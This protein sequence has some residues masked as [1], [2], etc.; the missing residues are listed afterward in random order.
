MLSSNCSAA[1]SASSTSFGVSFVFCCACRSTDGS[2]L[3]LAVAVL[4]QYVLLIL[5][6]PERK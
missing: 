5:L 4:L 6:L 2:L 1:R 3:L